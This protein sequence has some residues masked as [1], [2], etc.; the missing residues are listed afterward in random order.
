MLVML[1]RPSETFMKPNSMDV[2]SFSVRIVRKEE[3]VEATEATPLLL[4]EHCPRREVHMHKQ[5]VGFM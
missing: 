4:I 1:A 2:K 5:I 3:V